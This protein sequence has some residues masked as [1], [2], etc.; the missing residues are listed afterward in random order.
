MKSETKGIWKTLLYAGIV[1]FWGFGYYKILYHTPYFI[2]F[3]E[4]DKNT[5]RLFVQHVIVN[6]P[7]LL[8]IFFCIVRKRRDRIF[9]KVPE[10]KWGRLCLILL[11]AVYA[12]LLACSLK[13]IGNTV[14]TVYMA[15]FYLFFVSFTEEF[16]YRGVLPA[17]LEKNSVPVRW[18]LPNILFSLAHVAMLFVSDDGLEGLS[19]WSICLYIVSTVLT[20]LVFELAK[21]KSKSLYLPILLHAVYDFFGEIMLWL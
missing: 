11:C 17:L 5:F 4:A 6:L 7:P 2:S 20:G 14:N 18:L 10:G 21:R 9:M 1:I 13:I 8:C 19:N 16:V 3:D 15:V 12:A